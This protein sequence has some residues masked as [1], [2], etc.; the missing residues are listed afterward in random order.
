MMRP[1]NLFVYFQRYTFVSWV[2]ILSRPKQTSVLRSADMITCLV[3]VNTNDKL[4]NWL[5][6]LSAVC[7]HWATMED[8]SVLRRSDLILTPSTNEVF[9]RA[10]VQ[11]LLS[12][13][14]HTNEWIGSRRIPKILRFIIRQLFTSSK[15]ESF[16]QHK[17]MQT[18]LMFWLQQVSRCWNSLAFLH[19]L[20]IFIHVFFLS[21]LHFILFMCE[22]IIPGVNFLGQS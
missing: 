8:N 21:L 15:L 19:F 5:T 17:T 3:T 4:V 11:P 22:K 13:D 9:V 18:P 20:C 7:S 14:N 6:Q 12:S 1:I 10:A 16:K 2:V